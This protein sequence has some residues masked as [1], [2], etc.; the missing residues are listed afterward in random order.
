MGIDKSEIR[1]VVLT[2]MA[3]Q[4]LSNFIPVGVSARHVHLTKEHIEL[5]FGKGYELDPIRPLTQPQ[6]FV[7]REQV[8]VVGPKGRLEH[9]RI[10][11]PARRE[12]QVEISRTD[13]YTLGEANCPVRLS[14]DLEDTPGVTIIGLKGQLELKKGLII[15]ARHLHMNTEQARAFGI[16][17]K[18]IVSVKVSGERSCILQNIICRTGE[19][20]ELE[21]HLDTDEAN[22]CS[23]KTGDLVEI[24]GPGAKPILKDTLSSYKYQDELTDALPSYNSFVESNGSGVCAS[25]HDLGKSSFTGLHLDKTTYISHNPDIMMHGDLKNL[26][27]PPLN[28]GYA[29]IPEVWKRMTP[30]QKHAFN[31][32]ETLDKDI[33]ASGKIL[34]GEILE[35]LVTEQDINDAF[36]DDKRV[37]YCKHKAL[38]TPL[39]M[40]RASAMGIKIIRMK[41]GD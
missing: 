29:P 20:H 16:H 8:T 2:V 32:V 40:E 22:A 24:V 15:A 38:I 5:L 7:S 19:A 31:P 36:R 13:A 33:G 28:N 11:G 6:Q 27:N 37:L 34:D 1:R 25:R 12:S 23:V 26:K 30:A 17:D 4:N 35:D 39:A 14:G 21:L 18:Q 9:V 41:E 3:A 10:L